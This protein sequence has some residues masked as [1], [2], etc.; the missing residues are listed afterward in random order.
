MMEKVIN[1]SQSWLKLKIDTTPRLSQLHNYTY[2]TGK[3]LLRGGSPFLNKKESNDTNIF[4][5]KSS[6]LN[7]LKGMVQ[8]PEGFCI[9][10]PWR[11]WIFHRIYAFQ[12][13][14]TKIQCF[15]GG[16]RIFCN[17]VIYMALLLFWHLF[18]RNCLDTFYFSVKRG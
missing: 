13:T 16:H 10:V 6:F 11:E 17:N 8:C 18:Q 9:R 2:Y 4:V 15:H 1:L 12:T 7:I 14:T 3:L 5:S